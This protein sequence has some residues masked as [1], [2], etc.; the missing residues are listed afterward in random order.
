MR[1]YIIIKITNCTACITNSL[2]IDVCMCVHLYINYLYIY[3][4][5]CVC[6]HIYIFIVTVVEWQTILLKHCC[7]FCRHTCKRQIQTYIHIRK[8]GVISEFVCTS[9][10]F[11]SL[12][13]AANDNFCISSKQQLR[14][15]LMCGIVTQSRAHTHHTHT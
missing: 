15:T 9:T 2:C 1:V 10:A 14:E 4:Y 3:T 12:K 8:L 7:S 11:N 13:C 6:M 5:V